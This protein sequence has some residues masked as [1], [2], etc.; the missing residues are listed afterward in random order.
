M[1]RFELIGAGRIGTVH[2]RNIAAHPEAVLACITDLNK[3]RAAELAD[4]TGRPP[5]PMW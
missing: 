4:Q 3:A 1:L 5:R 2:G